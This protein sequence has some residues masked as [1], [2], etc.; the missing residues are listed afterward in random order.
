MGV[1]W[2][3]VLIKIKNTNVY[4]RKILNII[5][6]FFLG[7]LKLI[8]VKF[9]IYIILKRYVLFLRHIKSEMFNYLQV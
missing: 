8:I 2:L 5:I 3:E 9:S 4:I 6:F 1:N 7:F